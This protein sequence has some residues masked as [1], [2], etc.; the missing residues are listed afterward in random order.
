LKKIG[1]IT[2]FAKI[3]NIFNERYATTADNYN[4]YYPA[5]PRNLFVGVNFKF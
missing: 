3:N 5:N 1:D 2:L 4:G